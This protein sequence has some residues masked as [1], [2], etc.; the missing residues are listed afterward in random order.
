MPYITTSDGVEMFYTSHG[1]GQPV[2][3]SHGW[4]LNSDEWQLELKS[5]ADAGYLAIAH[6]R[7]G[8]GRSGPAYTGHD[9]TTYA[10]DLARMIDQ[11]GLDD[12]V[13]VGHGAGAG[14]V[15]RYASRF[16]AGRV[17]RIVTISSPAPGP[18]AGSADAA[19]T[20][21]TFDGLRAG[22]IVDTAQFFLDLA[23]SYFGANRT[24]ARVSRGTIDDFWRQSM[25]VRTATA[26]D[27][28][29][30]FAREDFAED[31]RA[32][33]R[34]ILIVHGGDDQ[35]IPVEAATRAQDLVE[36][37]QLRI[38]PGAPHGLHG[39]YRRMLRADILDFLQTPLSTERPRR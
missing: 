7:R 4:P 31:L 32:V 2:C 30:A 8:H 36:R 6:D 16:G 25:L 10:R 35:I 15:L 5:F 24:G 9:M 26:I 27:A 34:P 17:A 37:S 3:F 1:R 29:G 22:L 12:V 18:T 28:L 19:A 11:L 21:A 33:T 14:E 13:L 39:E 38:Y 23:A 20:D